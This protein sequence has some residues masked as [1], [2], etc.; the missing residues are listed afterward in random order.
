MTDNYGLVA[1]LQDVVASILM[2]ATTCCGKS[3][4]FDK[5]D[6]YCQITND[7]SFLLPFYIIARPISATI[8]GHPGKP[9]PG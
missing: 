6:N 5:A 4:L 2:H 3:E 7:K 9:F 1:Q 8:L